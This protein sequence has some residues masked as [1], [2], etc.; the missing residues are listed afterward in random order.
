MDDA[1]GD[2]LMRKISR[3]K[4]EKT[5]G[6]ILSAM[7]FDNG[8]K[9][10]EVSIINENKKAP[11]FGFYIYPVL[12]SIS[13]FAGD[14]INKEIGFNELCKKWK[15]IYNWYIEIDA[16]CFDRSVFNFSPKELTAMTI[17]EI[18]HTIYSDKPVERWYRAYLEAKSRVKLSERGGAK[19]LYQLYC[20]PLAVACIQKNWVT[21]KNQL[22]IEYAAD[23]EALKYGYGDP[24]IS[25]LNKIIKASGSIN[26]TDAVADKN[27]QSSVDWCTVNVTDLAHRRDKLKDELFYQGLK[28]NSN[29]FKAMAIYLLDQLGA[30]MR[31]RYTGAAIEMT[32]DIFDDP[33]VME[34]YQ[35]TMEA[36][37][38]AK[39]DRLI[40]IANQ[41]YTV[42]FANE[43][44]GRKKS[45]TPQLPSQYEIDAISIEI[46]KIENHYDRTYVLDLIYKVL[47]DITVFEDWMG[48]S[49]PNKLKQYANTIA[50]YRKEL[51]ELRKSCLAKKN[52]E[53][54][55][56]LFVKY[57]TGYEG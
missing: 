31:E 17:H 38:M 10:F 46:D 25:A 40:D 18:G 11:F 26:D 13:E 43:A 14:A 6:G 50:R 21:P 7:P 37:T 36:A 15:T 29:Y 3:E 20:V 49:D 39:W 56:R 8:K 30:G 48:E 44:F 22:K 35:I 4:F 47:D 12:D 42:D 57:P 52:L 41:T 53:K 51:E 54:E 1:Y 24:L 32:I 5:L 2:F 28:T 19:V 16:N 55:Y 45:K 27:V 9:H 34:H 33:K 23:R